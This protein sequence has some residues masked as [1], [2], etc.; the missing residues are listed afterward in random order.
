[1]DNEAIWKDVVGYEGI[2]KVSNKGE[3][4]SIKRKR[5]L[6]PSISKNGYRQAK[7]YKNG[8]YKTRSVHRIVA[9]AFL[10][11]PENYPVVNHVDEDKL[12][13]NVENLQWCTQKHNVN[14]GTGQQRRIEAVK[15]PVKQYTLDGQ[16]LATYKSAVD[17]QEL[18]GFHQSA[19][20]RV[21]RGERKTAYKYIWK[22]GS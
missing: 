1:M 6:N 20:S 14:H 21:C 13:N 2:Y 5:K 11:N 18:Y 22:Y 16:Y 3:L 17:L 9:T 10:E 4:Y 12:K 19:I 8:K 7:L 15:M